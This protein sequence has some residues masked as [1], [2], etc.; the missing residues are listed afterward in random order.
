MTEVIMHQLQ[1]RITT[2]W[3]TIIG[4]ATLDYGLAKQQNKWVYRGYTQIL[5][6][7]SGNTQ[8]A[9]GKQQA[10][11][12]LVYGPDYTTAFNKHIAIMSNAFYSIQLKTNILQNIIF[13]HF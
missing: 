8:T 7:R 9:R 13:Y 11:G 4:E 2:V 6:L 12:V 5:I 1:Q 3:D 10:Y